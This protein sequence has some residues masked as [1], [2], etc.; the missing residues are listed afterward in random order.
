MSGW[1]GGKEVTKPPPNP[2]S[3]TYEDTFIYIVTYLKLKLKLYTRL[4]HQLEPKNSL[5]YFMAQILTA[6]KS[7]KDISTYKPE[8]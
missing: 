4:Y 1:G 5:L 7:K 6:S 2:S 3:K 8:D